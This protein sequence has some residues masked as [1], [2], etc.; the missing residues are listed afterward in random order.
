MSMKVAEGCF[1]EYHVDN[2]CSVKE[3]TEANGLKFAKGK[4]FYKLV[5]KENVQNYKTVIVKRRSDGSCITGEPVKAL[6]KIEKKKKALNVSLNATDY[7]DFDIFIQSSSHNRKLDAGSSMLFQLK[8]L[9]TVVDEPAVKADKRPVPAEVEDEDA[10][11]AKKAKKTTGGK[12]DVVFSFD[13]T[14][15]MYACLAEVRRGVKE[16]IRRLK[17]EVRDIRIAIIAHGD[18]C[19]AHGSYVTKMVGFTEDETL[20]CNFVQ[21]VGATGGGDADEC[22]ELVL[23]EARTKLKW[24]PGSTR[25]SFVILSNL[26]L[27]DLLTQ[28]SRHDWGLQ[29]ARTKLPTEHPED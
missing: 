15:S 13:T 29:P 20:L 19:D 25:Y 17:A 1:K 26:M 5:K 6:L 24:R 2:K 27:I 16:A 4:V 21:T 9:E 22:Y 7:P 12:V 23:K 8:D 18:Y 11:K 14:G 3:F 10:K 28:V